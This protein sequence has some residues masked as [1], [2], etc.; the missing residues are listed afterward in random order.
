VQT[1]CGQVQTA[2]PASTDI[3]TIC[4]PLVCPGPISLVKPI[5]PIIIPPLGTTNCRK[6]LVLNENTKRYEWKGICS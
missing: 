5:Q 4:G 3:K 2:C 1:I 6:M